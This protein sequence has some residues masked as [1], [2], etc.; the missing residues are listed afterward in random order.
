MLIAVLFMVAGGKRQ[1]QYPPL[2]GMTGNSS[3]HVVPCGS[4]SKHVAI[5][6]VKCS[7]SELRCAVNVN[8]FS[9]EA[10]LHL[11]GKKNLVYFCFDLSS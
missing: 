6:N 7:Y 3:T 2:G 10:R 5:E 11:G 9:I 4:H 8:P 1:L